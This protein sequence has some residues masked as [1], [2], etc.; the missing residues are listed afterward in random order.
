M[1][2]Y[3]GFGRLLE[4]VRVVEM[5]VMGDGKKSHVRKEKEGKKI[6]L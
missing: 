5:V 4:F 1:V 6:I 2:C 3:G